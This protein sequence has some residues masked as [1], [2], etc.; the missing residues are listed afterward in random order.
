MKIA[1]EN[2][3]LHILNSNEVRPILSDCTLPTNEHINSYLVKNIE[4]AF[5]SDNVK[6]CVFHAESSLWAQCNNLAWNL[7]AI[8]QS[9][10]NDIYTIMRRN[11]EIPSADL[12][13]GLV[14][15]DEHTYFFM[16]KFDYRNAFTHY[17]EKGEYGVKVSLIKHNTLFP[18]QPIQI[19]EGF[20]IDTERPSVKIIEQKYNVDGIKDFYISSQILGCSESNTARQKTTKILNAAQKVSKLY[21]SSED[22]MNTHI[23]AAIFEELQQNNS[24]SVDRLGKRFFTQNPVAQDEFFE[25]LSA[26]NISREEELSLSERFQRKFQKQAIKTI[27]GVEIKIP[28]QVYSNT[29]EIEFINNPD[30]TVSLLIK[31]IKI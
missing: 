26:A 25:I 5:S 20:F 14:K 7:V 2:T 27:S 23:S 9:I 16:L 11:K 6:N 12:L 10:A 31:N 30:G 8:S 22:D 28:T 13:F 17:V 18:F 15:I 24:I 4:K 21:Y 3:I 29:D 19:T 1:I